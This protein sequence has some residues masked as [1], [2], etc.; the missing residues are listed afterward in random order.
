MRTQVIELCAGFERE[1][2]GAASKSNQASL[3]LPAAQTRFA[4]FP[5]QLLGG[6][7]GN[8]LVTPPSTAIAWPVTYDAS[9][10]ARNSAAVAISSGW[11][12]R[13]SAQSWPTRRSVPR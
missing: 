13:A 2:T 3:Q 7:N 1:H 10:L 5:G 11:P 8:V 9:S 6:M 12:A 4:R